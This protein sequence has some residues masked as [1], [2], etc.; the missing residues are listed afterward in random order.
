M[1][2]LTRTKMAKR[3]E[4]TQFL[5]AFICVL[6]LVATASAV[7]EQPAYAKALEAGDTTKAIDLLTSSIASDKNFHLNYYNLGRIY[8][9]Q[10]KFE[11]A[12]QQFSKA[13]DKKNSHLPSRFFWG[14]S[15]LQQKKY[16]EAFKVFTKGQKKAKKKEKFIFDY[17]LGLVHLER[18]EYQDAI[19]KFILVQLGD[20]KKPELRQELYGSDYN[21]ADLIISLG[22]ANFYSKVYSSAIIQFEKAAAMG[23]LSNE[24]RYH[25][26][27]ACLE[28]KNFNCAIDNLKS[29]LS[30]DS[31]HAESWERL[32][33][34][35]FRAALSSRSR[36]ERNERAKETIGSYKKYLELSKTKPDSSSVRVFFGLA[37][38]Y[39]YLNAFEQAI[40][41]FED[42]LAIPY[43]ARDIYFHYGKALRWGK[44]DYVKA[45]E[46][47]EK[48]IAWVE[49]Q[50]ADYKTRVSDMELNLLLGDCYFRRKD[51]DYPKAIS[52]YLKVLEVK[53]DHSRVLQSVA[54]GY[55]SMQDY[56]N[57]LVYYDRRIALGIDTAAAGIYKNAGY[58]AMNLANSAVEDEGEDM[59]DALGEEEFESSAEPIDADSMFARSIGYMEKYLELKPGDV[60]I[61]SMIAY[62][63]LYRMNDCANGVKYYQKLLA[64][65]PDNCEAKK[66]IGFAYFGGELCTTNY[67][68]ALKYLK[69]AHSCISA[70]EGGDCSDVSLVLYIAQCYHLRAAQKAAAKEDTNSDY[71]NAYT[72]Y[73]KVL[74]CEPGNKEAK[75]GQDDT[76]FEFSN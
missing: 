49:E 16:D 18:G 25:W 13:I 45:A 35:Y 65:E 57:A 4:L 48:H 68:K 19:T 53:P 60:K 23:P 51:K 40:D 70:G 11:E 50:G 56:Q 34:I 74:K 55:H 26:A 59:D 69:E 31:T 67:T 14:L 71:K 62:T 72:W 64:I 15:A 39:S 10:G 27:E 44:K 24:T 42:V 8:Y 33:D 41:Y 54:I 58:C 5:L 46:M 76:Q 29:V 12:E 37:L 22:E 1:N 17:G 36:S 61:V 6:M 73:G 7:E 63:Y 75:K 28:T 47:L 3:T 20:E 52:H 30:E 38:S 21:K 2:Y 66:S 32:G 43:E 9:A